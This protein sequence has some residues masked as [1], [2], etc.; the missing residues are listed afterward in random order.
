MRKLFRRRRPLGAHKDKYTN[1]AE[2][3]GE[4][5]DR[6]YNCAQ[7]V[8]QATTGREDP[9]LVNLTEGFAGG[10]GNT[11]CL[12]GAITGGVMALGLAGKAD[13]SERLMTEFKDNFR[14]TCCKGLSKDHQWLSKEHLANCRQITMKTAAITEKLLDD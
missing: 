4:L 2:R 10:I 1:A 5:F 14:T 9:E 13:A 11:G 8:L 3:A 12:C 6:G 7:A